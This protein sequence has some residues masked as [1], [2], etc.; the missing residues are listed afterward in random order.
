MKANIP[1]SYNSLPESEKR[2]ITEMV[3]E[4]VLEIV[5]HEEAQMQKIWLKLACIVLHDG[6]GFGEQRLLTFLGNWKR[7]YKK[8]AKCKTDAEQSAWIGEQIDRIFKDGY[9][10]EFIDKFE[11]I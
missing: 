1:K 3:S 6:F 2:K 7:I 8:N 9:P 5:D 4:R 11:E 10:T